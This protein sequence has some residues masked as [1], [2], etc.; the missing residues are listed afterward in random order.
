[1]FSTSPAPDGQESVER[2][3]CS[4]ATF[5]CQR[6][7]CGDLRAC[8]RICQD[9]QQRPRFRR[10]H[11]FQDIDDTQIP[12]GVPFIFCQQPF[13]TAAE[14]QGDVA[15]QRLLDGFLGSRPNLFQGKCRCSDRRAIVRFASDRVSPTASF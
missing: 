13:R 8:R 9:L 5:H 11:V 1:M 15:L 7:R 4:T 10:C 6:G 14:F 3:L 2:F 12:C